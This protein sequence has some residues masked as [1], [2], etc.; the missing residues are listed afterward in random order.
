MPHSISPT[1]HVHILCDSTPSAGQRLPR[2]CGAHRPRCR[3]RG[4]HAHRRNEARR[5]ALLPACLPQQVL[6]TKDR[7][8]DGDRRVRAAAPPRGSRRALPRGAQAPCLTMRIMRRAPAPKIR[9]PRP[10]AWRPA[11]RSRRCAPRPDGFPDG[12]PAPSRSAGAAMMEP[13]SSR[14]RRPRAPARICIS[15]FQPIG[16]LVHAEPAEARRR[17]RR[18]AHMSL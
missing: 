6:R 15:M 14:M 8:R 4:R 3:R 13:G 9:R 18:N 17:M 1:R 16:H 5:Q 11:R 10:A 7:G 12:L 2:M